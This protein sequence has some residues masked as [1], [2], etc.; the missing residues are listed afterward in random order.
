MNLNDFT[1]ERLES[2]S[3]YTAQEIAKRLAWLSE[4]DDPIARSRVL[5]SLMS[6][7][8]ANALYLHALA[9]PTSKVRASF[10]SSV[11]ACRDLFA[12][13]ADESRCNPV[14]LIDGIELALILDDH[15]SAT[16]LASMRDY[17]VAKYQQGSFTA[18]EVVM[19]YVVALLSMVR[20]ETTTARDVAA[21]NVT[22]AAGLKEAHARRFGAQSA[23]L[24]AVADRDAA[25]FAMAMTALLEW[26]DRESRRGRLRESPEGLM[27]ISGLALVRLARNAAMHVDVDNPYLPLEILAAS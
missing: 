21:A 13:G 17:Q 2:L 23:A 22:R 27:C 5:E 20:A 9:Q 12:I 8:R 19:G 18:L 26:Q 14:A 10:R 6:A 11:A 4:A 7:W 15:E 24:V 16:A 1:G 25:G 3:A